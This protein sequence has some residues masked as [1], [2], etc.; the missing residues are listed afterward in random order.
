MTVEPLRWCHYGTA[1]YSRLGGLLMQ[2]GSV[3]V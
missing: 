2:N 1:L 3:E